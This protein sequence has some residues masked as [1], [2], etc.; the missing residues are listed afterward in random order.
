M[1]D[2]NAEQDPIQAFKALDA[3]HARIADHLVRLDALMDG[4]E[5]RGADAATQAEARAIEAFFSGT[6]SQ[7]HRDEETLVFPALLA[8]PDA[9]LVA[10]VRV[11]QQDHGW[12]EEDWLALAPRLRAVAGGQCDVDPAE[13]RHSAQVFTDL[14]REH[15]E[16]EESL[17]YPE[18]KA[19]LRRAARARSARRERLAPG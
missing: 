11:L 7:H 5:S 19:L 2:R 10:T 4:Y 16:L 6:S 18:A 13:L 9:E 15:I 3:C 17:I 1:N 12:I 8:G 14:V